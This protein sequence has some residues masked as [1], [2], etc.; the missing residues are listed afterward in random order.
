MG[1]IYNG[2]LVSTV[3]QCE[4]VIMYIYIYTFFQSVLPYRS[5]QNIEKI[6]PFYPTGPYQLSIIYIYI[7]SSVYI[8]ISISQFIPL[9]FLPM[10]IMFVFYVCDSISVL[11]ISLL[12]SIHFI[13]K[14]TV[15]FSL[16]QSLSHVQFF[17]TLWTAACQA[18]L[19]I[20]NSWGLTQ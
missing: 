2:A 19:S 15:Q 8:S 18:S 17:V 11:Q 6:S 4:S 12:Y 10:E 9:P 16:V 20:T 13:N 1:F 3:P 5:L 7:Y 14:F